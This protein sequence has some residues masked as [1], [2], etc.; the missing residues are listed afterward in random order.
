MIIR[1]GLWPQVSR[2]R[3]R[4]RRLHC[5]F[6]RSHEEPGE[7]GTQGHVRIGTRESRM[8]ISL[9]VRCNRGYGFGFPGGFQRFPIIT[10]VKRGGTAWNMC[11]CTKLVMCKPEYWPGRRGSDVQGGLERKSGRPASIWWC[12]GVGARRTVSGR[13]LAA[14]AQATTRGLSSRPRN[15]AAIARSLSLFYQA[16][17]HDRRA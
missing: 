1:Q 12:P 2:Q 16:Q 3:N 14:V 13:R 6:K 7:S 4:S 5:R 9:C 8:E 10:Q 11:H 15:R 17:N